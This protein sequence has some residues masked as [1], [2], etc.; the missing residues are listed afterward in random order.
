MG[1]REVILQNVPHLHGFK[2]LMH[3][4]VVKYLPK[5]FKS[6]FLMKYEVFQTLEVVLGRVRAPVAK[7]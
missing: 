2:R 4:N 5:G 3:Q 6:V 7:F 1:C